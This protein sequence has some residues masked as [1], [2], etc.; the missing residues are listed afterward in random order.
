[1]AVTTRSSKAVGVG[2]VLATLL[3]LWTSVSPIAATSKATGTAIELLAVL[4]TGPEHPAGY[5]RTLFRHWIDSDDDGCN[6]RLEVLIAEARGTPGV[7]DGCTVTGSWRSAYDAIVTTNPR[8]FDIDHVVPLKEAWDSGA[9]AWTPALRERYA[10]DLGDWRALRAVTAASNRS[11]ADRD[12]ADWLPPRVAF[13]CTYANDW[14][15][16]KIRW[17]LRVDADERTA[18]EALLALCPTKTLTVNVLATVPAAASPSGTSSS[19]T[20]SAV[21]TP[22]ASP[23]PTPS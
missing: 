7:G 20:S 14:I 22:G 12:P 9:W 23:T 21:A 11:K 13:R 19:P 15:A 6:T 5:N 2:L 4:G 3:L 10:N 18:L 8:T 1:M 16:V 17:S